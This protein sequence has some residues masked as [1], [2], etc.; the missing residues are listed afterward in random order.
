[1]K[2]AAQGRPPEMG[3]YD[4]DIEK[5]LAVVSD[6][7]SE[8]LEDSLNPARCRTPRET[9]CIAMQSRFIAYADHA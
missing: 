8:S 6:S 2:A 5:D 4:D 3:R 7:Q 9:A 1:M